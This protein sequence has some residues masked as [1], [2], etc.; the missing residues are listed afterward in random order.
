MYSLQD[1]LEFQIMNTHRLFKPTLIGLATFSLGTLDIERS[2]IGVEK[3]IRDVDATVVDSTHSRGTLLFDVFYFP[4]SLTS[5]TESPTMK[6]QV[7]SSS[8]L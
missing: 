1:I 5:K 7:T 4:V 8:M 2:M 3:V 6:S